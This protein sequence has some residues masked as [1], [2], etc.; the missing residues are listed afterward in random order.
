MLRG[1][2]PRNGMSSRGLPL[3]QRQRQGRWPPPLWS[4]TPIQAAPLADCV[5][6]RDRTER[7]LRIDRTH[8]VEP[9][10]QAAMWTD[11]LSVCLPSK[12]SV[13]FFSL[14]LR[15]SLR[16]SLCCSLFAPPLPCLPH[17]INMAEV[18]HKSAE[19]R[20]DVD[21]VRAR[22]EFLPPQWRR[23]AA[24]SAGDAR[25]SSVAAACGRRV[26]VPSTSPLPMCTAVLLVIAVHHS[27]GRGSC[28]CSFT[29]SARRRFCS[30]FLCPF[31]LSTVLCPSFLSPSFFFVALCA[32]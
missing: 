3:W 13:W 4:T 27:T 1:S 14:F 5:R 16:V 6:T 18:R 15:L 11:W 2:W 10:T 30:L 23:L 25:R 19:R 7:Y 31:L 12:S 17:L 24:R 29:L 22:I 20:G 9:S 8:R 28:S 32:V 26:V 21:A